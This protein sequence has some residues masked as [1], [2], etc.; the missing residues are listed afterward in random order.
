MKLKDN[1][2]EILLLSEQPVIFYCDDP[3]LIK[4]IKIRSRGSENE[5]N[6]NYQGR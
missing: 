4:T 1:F 3:Y 2:S 6:R 5:D